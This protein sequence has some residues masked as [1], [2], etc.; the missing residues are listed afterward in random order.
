MHMSHSSSTA[1][2][3]LSPPPPP[4]CCQT[5]ARSF[6]SRRH[7]CT[8]YVRISPFIA[9]RRKHKTQSLLFTPPITNRPTM[10]LLRLLGTRCRRA[11]EESGCCGAG[12]DWTR[13]HG[14]VPWQQPG[15][16]HATAGSI[17]CGAG[18]ESTALLCGRAARAAM[19]F[20][21]SLVARLQR[22]SGRERGKYPQLLKPGGFL[23]FLRNEEIRV[24]QPAG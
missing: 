9:R 1:C 2:T 14:A 15:S 6:P 18:A 10:L 23:V 5:K 13:V 3:P 19:G 8:L 16:G 7:P 24:T 11:D 20:I 22:R 21:L 4:R 17:V 12:R